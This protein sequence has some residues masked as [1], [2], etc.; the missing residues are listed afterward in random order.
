MFKEIFIKGYLEKIERNNSFLEPYFKHS[1]ILLS[2]INP[3][4]Y[5]IINC[6]MIEQYIASINCTN[7][8]LERLMKLALIQK[9]TEGLKYDEIEK[10]SSKL[11]IAYINYDKL[12]LCDSIDKCY[13]EARLITKNEFETLNKMRSEIRNSYSHAQMQ[14]INQGLPENISMQ[15]YSFKEAKKSIKNKTKIVSKEVFIP[16]KD[17]TLQSEFQKSYSKDLAINYFKTV[18]EIAISIDVKLD[19]KLEYEKIRKPF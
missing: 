17:P 14:K 18:Y 10:L 15:M 5:E 13:N 12:N 11:N 16:T 8:F 2:A 19:V 3:I 4:K 9:E 7:H 1:L 6:L